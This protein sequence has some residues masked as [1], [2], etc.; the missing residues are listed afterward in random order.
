[1]LF[2]CGIITIFVGAFAGMGFSFIIPLEKLGNYAF[3]LGGGSLVVAST[4]GIFYPILCVELNDATDKK[5][6]KSLE[7]IYSTGKAFFLV[8]TTIALTCGGAFSYAASKTILEQ[9]TVL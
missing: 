1:M 4:M 6:K 5:T 9:I 7:R 3:Y 2:Y 8:L